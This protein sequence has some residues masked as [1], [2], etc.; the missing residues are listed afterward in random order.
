VKPQLCFC[1]L[2][3]VDLH[4]LVISLKALLVNINKVTILSN[5]RQ[6]DMI[7]CMNKI[8]NSL[9]FNS[10]VSRKIQPIVLSPWEMR[11]TQKYTF[12]FK[13]L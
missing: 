9:V 6:C 1:S 5:H 11:L 7:G 10:R 13:N 3:F 2:Y 4:Y 12:T 8:I